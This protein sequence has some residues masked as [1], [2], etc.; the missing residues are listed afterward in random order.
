[1]TLKL[2]TSR[3]RGGYWPP[4]GARWARGPPHPKI[5]NFLDDDQTRTTP[6]GLVAFREGSW[7]PCVFLHCSADTWLSTPDSRLQHLG[8][9]L[10]QQS[11]WAVYL[12]PVCVGSP[13]LSSPLLESKWLCFILFAWCSQCLEKSLTRSCR[14]GNTCLI[15]LDFISALG[16]VVNIWW[17]RRAKVD[18]VRML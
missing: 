6:Q 14:S 4:G 10:G 8:E 3:W 5:L 11:R 13:H 17:E 7:E 16:S 1:M 18:K 12:A 2:R 15:E 9:H